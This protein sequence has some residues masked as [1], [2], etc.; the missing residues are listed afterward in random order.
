[1]HFWQIEKQNIQMPVVV[2]RLAK[3]W[4]DVLTAWKKIEV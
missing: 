2:Y 1:L 3:H 4:Q